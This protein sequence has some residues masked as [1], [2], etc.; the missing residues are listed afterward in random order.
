VSESERTFDRPIFPIARED[1]D[2]GLPFGH[3][4]RASSRGSGILF[5]LHNTVGWSPALEKERPSSPPLPALCPVRLS[6]IVG[7]GEAVL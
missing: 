7:S 2:F 3:V 4:V 5:T 6:A 1:T